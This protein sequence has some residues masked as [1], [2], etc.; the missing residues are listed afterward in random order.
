[1]IG[2]HKHLELEKCAASLKKDDFKE[3]CTL[4]LINVNINL[5]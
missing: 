4:R 2:F 3:S 1:M 5:L